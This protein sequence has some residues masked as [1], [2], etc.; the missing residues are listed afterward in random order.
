MSGTDVV[1]IGAVN[2]DLVVAAPRLPAPGETVVGP[3][4]HRHGGGKGAN[5]AV[6][7]A[8][9]GGRVYYVGAVGDDD[10]GLAALRELQDD[11][12]DVTHVEI[13]ADAPTGAALIVV[14]DT[15]ENQIAVGAGANNEV[16]AAH[17]H[18][19]LGRRLTTAGIVLVSTEIPGEAVAAAV[20][21]AHTAGVRCILNPAPVIPN[22]ADLLKLGPLITPNA[23]ELLALAEA[24]GVDHAV[25]AEQAEQAPGAARPSF[26]AILGCGRAMAE[27]TGSEV[28]VTLGGDGVLVI[29]P[30]GKTEHLLPH[31]VIVRDTTG[32]G[33]TFNGVLAAGLASGHALPEAARRA[34]AAAAMSVR[35]EGARGGM[36]AARAVD[37]FLTSG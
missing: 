5:A 22:L 33:D 21:A 14:N 18:D 28:V 24:A 9:A 31:H 16:T 23:G 37:A 34:N 17:V 11:H 15:G 20:R 13:I 3:G 29:A 27:L 35:S 25:H 7:A 19:A 32:A 8:R 12:V 6:A 10:L 4:V 36:P 2:V 1:V 30:D 26:A